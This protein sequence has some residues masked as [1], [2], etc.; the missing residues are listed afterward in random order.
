MISCKSQPLETVKTLDITKYAGTWYEIARLPNR[1]EKKLECVSATY[2]LIENGKVKVINRGISTEDH[3]QKKEITGKAWVPDVA[4]P[5]QLK[6]QFFW[7]FAGKYWV[8]DLGPEGGESGGYLVFE[9]RPEDLAKCRESY[10]GKYLSQK[11]WVS[12]PL[13]R[14][15]KQN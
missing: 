1:F 11:R 14:G 8:I 4:F 6:V 15:H 9:G 2:E 5:G 3:S 7:P 12:M 13:P 10:T